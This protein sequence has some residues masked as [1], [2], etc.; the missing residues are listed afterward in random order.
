MKTKL[1]AASSGIAGPVGQTDIEASPSRPHNPE[2]GNLREIP[3]T[4]RLLSTD[5]TQSASAVPRLESTYARLPEQF[6]ARLG[7]TGIPEPSLARLNRPLAEQLGLD[8]DWLMTSEGVEFLAGKRVADGA[9]PLAMAYAG[10]QFGQFV[11]SLGDGRALLLGELVGADGVRRDIHLKGSGRTP[12]SRSGDGRAPLG[13]VLREYILG[14]AMA[15][16]GVPTT[17]ALAVV[18]TGERVFRERMEP[19]AILARV[20]TSHVRVGT[21]EY[22]YRRGDLDSVRILSDYVIE[23]HYP[24]CREADNPYRAL[25]DEIVTRQADLL[26][27]WMLLG[28]IHGV[29]NTDNMSVCGETI[30]YGPCAFMDTYRP[31]AVYSSIDH[32]GRYAYNQQP[33]IAFWNLT[34]LAQC[35]L[36]LL[37]DDEDK[38]LSCARETL[39]TYASRFEASYHAGIRSKIGLPGERD[40]DTDLALD[41]LNRMSGERADYTNTFRGLCEVNTRDAA[42][43][44]HVRSLFEDADVFDEWAA[45]WR[46]RLSADNRTQAERCAAMRAVN[47]AYIPRNHRVQQAIDAVVL[48][49]DPASLENLL[50]VTGRPFEDNALL[51]DYARPPRPDEAVLRTFCGT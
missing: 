38:A 4:G 32:G 35:L 39:E 2:H 15:A 34:Q 30:D 45:R 21:F 49:G 25:L 44:G 23:R 3:P 36:S 48:E 24:Y 12:F 46:K 42:A 43:D 7:P 11:P 5:S 50:A 28:F 18:T 10:H 29:M 37:D 17:R 51:S 9:E 14:E 20:A 33:R 6:Y 13:P 27:Q 19:G 1:R 47:P 26:S 40:D 31:D 22:F 41:L 16:L 8:P